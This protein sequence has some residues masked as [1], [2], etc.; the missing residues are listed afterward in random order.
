MYE[1]KG[2]EEVSVDCMAA[3][4][5]LESLVVNSYLYASYVLVPV[6]V[7]ESFVFVVGHGVFR[8]C[9]GGVVVVFLLLFGFGSVVTLH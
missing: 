3:Y 6:D 9:V 8:C 2:E 1:C 5:F 4:Y 7:V